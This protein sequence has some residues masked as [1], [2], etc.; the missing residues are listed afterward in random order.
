MANFGVRSFESF[1][2]APMAIARRDARENPRRLASITAAADYL[3]VEHKLIRKMIAAG[4][5][6]G[7]RLPASNLIRVDLNEI[8]ALLD[9]GRVA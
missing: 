7:Y 8:D 6:T 2:D 4:K 9:R 5:I 1:G 3:A